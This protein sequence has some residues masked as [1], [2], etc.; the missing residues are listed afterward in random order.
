MSLKGKPEF[1]A[2]LRSIRLAFKPAGR[3]WGSD[4]VKELDRRTPRRTGK[5]ATSY[6]IRNNTQRKT[7][8]V[9]SYIANFID[10]GSKA[11]TEVPKRAKV[12]RF[13]AGGR[14]VFAKKVHKPRIGP[15]RFKRAAA[16]A[17]LQKNPLAKELIDQWNK[18]A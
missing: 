17:A 18:A 1:R 13:Q 16:L 2:R 11:H 7:T 4:A 14:T 6:R 8:V 3:A 9:G 10:A 15:R 5:T 12:L